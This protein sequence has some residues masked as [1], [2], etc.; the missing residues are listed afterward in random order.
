MLSWNRCNWARSDRLSFIVVIAFAWLGPSLRGAAAEPNENGSLVT[1][2][3]STNQKPSIDSTGRY[4]L[5]P[6]FDLTVQ[7]KVL[8]AWDNLVLKQ[9]EAFPQ[10]I[11]HCDDKDYSTSVAS[12]IFEHWHNWTVGQSCREIV[13]SNL[14][15]Y[16]TLVT[17]AL[18]QNP[19]GRLHRPHYCFAN[20]R[21]REQA[22]QWWKARQNKSLRELQIEVLEWILAEEQKEANKYAD[23]I[24]L[25]KP[26]LETLKKST[27]PLK[28]NE[29]GFSGVYRLGGDE[30]N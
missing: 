19:A 15:P 13:A 11:E 6:G 30:G 9:T 25:L 14:Q 20:L 5:P 27:E 10:L 1:A 2:L 23:D 29:T 16:G 21:T 22:A 3:R 17:S 12:T 7:S 18:R 8:A 24:A 4:K 28:P 26:R